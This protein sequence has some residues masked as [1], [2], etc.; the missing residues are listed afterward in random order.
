MQVL[1]VVLIVHYT[2][3]AFCNELRKIPDIHE[4]IQCTDQ[5]KSGLVWAS[6]CPSVR[7]NVVLFCFLLPGFV[8]I[9]NTLIL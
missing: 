5:T 3:F 4:K 2:D 8:K 9:I 7:F 6:C 1:K